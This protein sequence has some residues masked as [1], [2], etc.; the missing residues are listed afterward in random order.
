MCCWDM[1]TGKVVDFYRKNWGSIER[2]LQVDKTLCIHHG[3]YKKG[4]YRHYHAVCSMNDFVG[5]LLDLGDEHH[6]FLV[7][8]AGCGIGGTV[9][10]L[11][12]QYP[13][14]HFTGL[15]VVPDH[16]QVAK[17]LARCMQV[18]ANTEFIMGD[19]AKISIVSGVYDAIF[20]LE[21]LC[22]AL[23]KPLV[24]REL[25][26]VLKPG[27]RLVIIDAFR[28]NVV[29]NL[30]M[31]HIY[32][33]FCDGWGLPH[34]SRLSELKN[35]LRREGFC[36]VAV[37][38]LKRQIFPSVVRGIMVG[39]PYVLL[40]VLR[41]LVRGKAYVMVEDGCFLAATFVLSALLGVKKAITY[42]AVTAVK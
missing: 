37:V 24:I 25:F 17:R 19:F 7:L 39:S 29:L 20:L 9:I 2:L 34:L 12:Q 42:A 18:S 35:I 32:G 3:L 1:S 8:D 5:Q 26:R 33:W 21:S 40:M 14:I 16:V 13:S 11:A 27:G 28:T 4:I 22:Y 30:F 23:Q 10:Y 6:D 15:T 41:K 36:D 31:T 38:D